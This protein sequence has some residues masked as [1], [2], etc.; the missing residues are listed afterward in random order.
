M[1]SLAFSGLGREAQRQ[2]ETRHSASGAGEDPALAA[3]HVPVVRHHLVDQGVG[4]FS[5]AR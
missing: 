1:Q 5:R 4:S 2:H 3:H